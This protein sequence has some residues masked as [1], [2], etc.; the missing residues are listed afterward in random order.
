MIRYNIF[1]EKKVF[2][3]DKKYYKVIDKYLS[4]KHII[5]TENGYKLNNEVEN[6][7]FLLSNMI[8]SEFI[9]NWLPFFNDKSII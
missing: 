3:F 6:N 7:G 8:L 5:K 1:D 2:D 4:S 9:E